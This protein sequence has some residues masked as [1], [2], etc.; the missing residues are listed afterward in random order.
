MNLRTEDLPNCELKLTL[1]LDA[2][3]VNAS[4]DKI[5][6]DLNQSGQ[7]H[8][9]RPGKVPKILLRR[10]FGPDRIRDMAWYE[11]LQQ[12]LEEPLKDLDLVSP[13]DFPDPEESGLIEDQPLELTVTAFVGRRVTLG[14]MAG[15]PIF[16]PPMEASDERVAEVL[17]QL[18]ETHAAEVKP[19]GRDAVAVG[20]AVDLEVVVTLEG[21]EEPSDEMEQTVIAGKGTYFPPIHEKLAGHL[22]GQTVEMEVTY[23]EDYQDPLLAGEAAKVV[24]KITGFRQRILPELDDEL[25]RKVDPEKLQTFDDLRAEVKRQLDKER[26]EYARQELELQVSR[27]LLAR[28]R[29]EV[30]EAMVE[31]LAHRQSRDLLE[32]LGEYGLDLEHFQDIAGMSAE[33]FRAS[34]RRRARNLLRLHAVYGEFTKQ[35]EFGEMSDEELLQEA[36]RFAAERNM[37]PAFV[38]QAASVQEDLREDLAESLRRRKVV[39]AVLAMADLHDVPLEEYLSKRDELVQLP[40]EVPEP[41]VEEP[42]SDDAAPAEPEAEAATEVTAEPGGEAAAEAVAEPTVEAPAEA[43]PEA[44]AEAVAEPTVEAPAEPAPPAEGAEPAPTA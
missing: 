40:E 29:V 22:V 6:K 26:A 33:D 37:D 25:A 18:R 28:S 7:V 8:G 44:A 41:P 2:T 24:A 17:E 35:Q 23:P 39:D 4:F 9:F 12:H 5:Y 20:D 21:D 13:P 1:S 36:E 38:K 11:L 34:Q 31:S 27:G 16:R 43:E 30:A 15:L 32:E 3:D 10:H 42:A 19:E 14:D